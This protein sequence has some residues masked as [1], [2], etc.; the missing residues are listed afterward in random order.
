LDAWLGGQI[1]EAIPPVLDQFDGLIET[2]AQGLPSEDAKKLREASVRSRAAIVDLTGLASRESG[3]RKTLGAARGRHVPPLDRNR[4][5]ALVD[6]L[7]TAIA[8]MDRRIL[9]VAQEAVV[10][11]AD[12]RAVA[13]QIG[14]VWSLIIYDLQEP[15]WRQYPELGPNP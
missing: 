10:P 12:S 2:I 4:A 5:K 1:L 3:T 14:E 8:V 11:E 7:N 15:L 13:S 9:K 6:G